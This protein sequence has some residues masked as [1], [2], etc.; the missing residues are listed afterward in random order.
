[1]SVGPK[2]FANRQYLAEALWRGGAEEKS[3]AVSL[4]EAVLAGAPSP[5][6]LV[7]DLSVQEQARANLAEWKKSS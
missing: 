1:V 5:Q 3:E 4:E 7:E 6:H 2:N